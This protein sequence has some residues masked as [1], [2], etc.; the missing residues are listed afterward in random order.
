MA[1]YES[2][3]K[4]ADGEYDV[5]VLGTGLKECILSGLL[6]V[7]GRK[8]LH[9]D[10]NDY[11]GGESASITPLEKLYTLFKKPGKPDAKFGSGRDWNV[12]LI[13]KLIMANGLLVKMLII[14]DVTR[15]LEFKSVEGSYVF[16]AG[17][18]HKVPVTE[19]EALSS[20]LMGIFEK[21]R[22]RS[23]LMWAHDFDPKNPSTW[24]GRRCRKSLTSLAWIATLPTLR[25]M[26]L[27]CTRTMTTSTC[28]A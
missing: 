27:L 6:S 22:F 13:P 3:P 9:M 16:K 18:L 24:Q 4:L 2:L 20:S 7:S 5:I 8:V 23:F 26:L 11:Y 21:R 17:K 12:D 28:P 1:A 14:T 10:R 25:V 15:Y 19:K